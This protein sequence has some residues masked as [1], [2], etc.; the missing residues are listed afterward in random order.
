MGRKAKKVTAGSSEPVTPATESSEPPAGQ[1]PSGAAPAT[2]ASA[3]AAP[4]PSWLRLIELAGS[5][6]SE[7][8][9]KDVVHEQIA[10]DL[11][12]DATAAR[13]NVMLLYDAVAIARSDTDQLYRALN[14]SSRDKPLLLILSSDGGDVGAAYFIAKICR[15]FSDVSFEVAVP[16]RAKSAA[17]LICCGAE[18]IH[19]GS[20][21][22]LGPIDPQFEGVPA[23]ALK[24]SIEHLAELT[25]RY[26]QAVDLFAA[27][28]SK[29]LRIEAL[30][31]YERVAE[32]AAQY[33][34]R[35]LRARRLASVAD[36][37][38][39][40]IAERL[41]YMYKDHGFVIDAAE[42]TEIFGNAVVVSNTPE[43]ALANRLYRSLDI[44]ERIL[45][46]F[47]SMGFAFTGAPESGCH[48][49][50][51]P[52]SQPSTA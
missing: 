48:L 47:H 36:D 1:G 4:S 10:Q 45:Q 41:L 17:T 42:A 11:A 50:R 43:Y 9:L 24:N 33:A 30:G 32:S 46:D 14:K 25:I 39:K 2:T 3:A 31:Y 44:M 34:E 8:Q 7:Q 38:I 28:L 52:A 26:P 16:R 21:S 29:T 37:R 12:D 23:L 35:L 51:R 5:S 19:M 49:R 20:L 18:R 22:E 13:Y 40:A 6:P 27:Y 15:E